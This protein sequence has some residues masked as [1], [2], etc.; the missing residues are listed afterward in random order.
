MFRWFRKWRWQF[1]TG[2]IVIFCGS[3]L[4]IFCQSCLAD[5]K[6]SDAST[7]TRPAHHCMQDENSEVNSDG[8]SA[9]SH[10]V[11]VC[12]CDDT[13]FFISDNRTPAADA[14]DKNRYPSHQDVLAIDQL[15]SAYNRYADKFC[16][17]RPSSPDRAHYLPIERFCVLLN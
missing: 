2:M 5:E 4:S 14:M 11:G 12:D 7:D 16:I 10:C 3:I 8:K 6:I 9:D 13:V 15:Y 17:S 1:S